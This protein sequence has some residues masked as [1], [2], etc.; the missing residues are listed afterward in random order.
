MQRGTW[1][2]LAAK[3]QTSGLVGLVF[4][5]LIGRRVSLAEEVASWELPVIGSTPRNCHCKADALIDSSHSA[6]RSG[7]DV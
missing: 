2:A 6:G 3:K 4:R 1:G 5:V 7:L